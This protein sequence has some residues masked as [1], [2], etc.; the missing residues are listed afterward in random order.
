MFK[1]LNITTF[2][3]THMQKETTNSFLNYSENILFVKIKEGS[4]ITIE[5]VKEEYDS[6]NK[7]V[8]DDEYVVL[9]DGA[10]N[11]I[12]P[13]DARKYMANHH[14][15][16]WK[17]TAIVTNNNLSTHLIANFYLRTNK[18]IVPTKLFKYEE[19]AIIWL[20]SKLENPL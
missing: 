14:T 11:F 15:P 17:A 13:L 3:N 1:Y 2:N 19:G 12:I 6:Q 16:N 4:E 9:I 5:S 7:M 18:P 10:L 8:G 20:K